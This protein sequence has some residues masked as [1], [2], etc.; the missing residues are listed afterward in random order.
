MP[1]LGYDVA[2][3]SGRITA[4]SK[5]GDLVRAIFERYVAKG[6]LIAVAQELRLRGWRRNSWVTRDG[7]IPA[8]YIRMTPARR[9][10]SSPAGRQRSRSRLRLIAAGLVVACL[11]AAAARAAADLHLERIGAPGGPPR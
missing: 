3:E 6:S 11:A 5:D 4:N 1:P 8:S 2:P 9:V 7:K 10:V